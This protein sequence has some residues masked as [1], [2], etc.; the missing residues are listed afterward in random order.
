MSAAL[1]QAQENSPT[2]TR[3]RD[4]RFSTFRNPLVLYDIVR[5]VALVAASWDMGPSK[6]PRTVTQ[7]SWNSARRSCAAFYGPI[8]QAHEVCRQLHDRD[9][10]DFKWAELLELVFDET[11]DIKKTHEDRL[12]EPQR[13]PSPA[14]VA[15]ALNR[16]AFDAKLHTLLPHDYTEHRARLLDDAAKKGRAEALARLLPTR[17]Q[18]ETACGGWDRALETAGLPPRSAYQAQSLDG[19]ELEEAIVLFYAGHGHLPTYDEV[20]SA[21]RGGGWRL[22]SAKG[23][24]WSEWIARATQRIEERGMPAPPPYGRRPPDQWTPIEV[25]LRDVPKRGA[26]RYT[27]AEVVEAV[28]DFVRTLEGASPTHARWKAFKR[29]RDEIPSLNVVIAHGGLR[30]LV[31]E[32]ARPDW[33][34]RAETWHDPR[35]IGEEEAKERKE[36]ALQRRARTPRA[37]AVHR[38]IERR[39]RATANEIA[40]DLS[41]PIAKVRDCL[42]LLREAGRIGTTNPRLQSKNQAYV[43]AGARSHR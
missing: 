15:H 33:R 21:A 8:P 27:H 23:R 4:G 22:A 9:G 39:G 41:W 34:E 10:V 30:K 6:D 35:I 26:K 5:E 17:G 42:R 3:T 11:R 37:E 2:V 38:A 43:V 18:I 13:V 29:D 32:A 1:A 36:K 7:R 40:D 24:R 16:V 12:S 14:R 31:R 19:M 25:G 20:V 28:R